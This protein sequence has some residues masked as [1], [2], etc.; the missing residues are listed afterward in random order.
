MQEQDTKR[1]R[2]REAAP[3][4]NLSVHTLRNWRREGKGP[5]FCRFG[6]SI[7]YTSEQLREYIEKSKVE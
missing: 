5:K 6:R 1:Y 2:D 3:I 4:L 7:R